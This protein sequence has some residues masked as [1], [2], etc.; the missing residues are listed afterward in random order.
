MAASQLLIHLIFLML[1]FSDLLMSNMETADPGSKNVGFCTHMEWISPKPAL[2][3]L[4]FLAAAFQGGVTMYHVALPVFQSK[5][6]GSQTIEELK[7]PSATTQLSQTICV[8]PFCL[9]RFP[10]PIYHQGKI[11]W[12]D[13]GPHAHPTVAILLNGQGNNVDYARLVVASCIVPMYGIKDTADMAK[14]SILD[15]VEWKGAKNESFPRGLIPCSCTLSSS[16]LYYADMGIYAMPFLS[17]LSLSSMALAKQQDQSQ[18]L[19]LPLPAVGHSFCSTPFGLNS[20]GGTWLG[21]EGNGTTDRHGVFHVFSVFQC[22]RKKAG[23]SN[24]SGTEQTLLEWTHPMRRHWLVRTVPG[25][26]KGAQDNDSAPTAGASSKEEKD[27]DDGGGGGGGD[28]VVTGGAASSVVCELGGIAPLA[29]YVPFSIVRSNGTYTAVLFRASDRLE[30]ECEKIAMIEPKEES[31]TKFRMVQLIDGQDIV[32]LPVSDDAVAQN[33]APRALI[34]GG[35]EGSKATSITMYQHKL[36]PQTKKYWHAGAAHRPILGVPPEDA[37]K[38]KGSEESDA[39]VE[40][41]KIVLS[42]FKNKVALL[43]VG[44][45][46]DDGRSCIISG[47]ME[48]YDSSD[49][50]SWSNL[51]PNIK[52]DPVFWFE[53]GEE[54]TL[55]ESLPWEQDIRGGVAVATN[56]RVLIL[57]PDEKMKLLGELRV[58]MSPSSLAPV[59]SFTVMFCSSDNRIRYVSGLAGRFGSGLIATLPMP[60]YGYNP[61][62]L[63]AVRP[64]RLLHFNWHCG[65]RLVE[66][67]QP[68]STFLLPTAITR[69]A[70]LLEP[71]LANAISTGGKDVGTQQFLRTIA[72]KFGRKVTSITH[73]DD[74]GIGNFGAGLTPKVFELLSRYEL[75][76]VASWFLTGT[77]RFDRLANSRLLPSWMPI[78]AKVHAALDADTHLHLIANGDQYFSEY[79]KS[80]D[81]NMTSTLPRPTDPSAFYCK[82]YA[83]SA[84]QDGNILDALKLLDIAGTESSESMLLQVSLALQADPFKDTTKIIESLFHSDSQ[85]GKSSSCTATAS[86]AALAQEIKAKKVQAGQPASEDFSKRW[87]KSLAPSLLRGKRTGRIRQRIIGE[88]AF[89]K[90]SSTNDR[91]KGSNLFSTELSEVRHVW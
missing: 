17:N 37:D 71:M 79:V 61:H 68:T 56:Q 9:A 11:A 25:D 24:D 74:E 28:E 64:D 7:K 20:S 69:P 23:T 18:P 90:I 72:E 43:A 4:L 85:M 54:V 29:N 53:P 51:L 89:A 19:S 13:L 77:V 57:S 36:N 21:S 44:T 59:G 47:R 50:V 33:G 52:E 60:R 42:R 32:F 22:E 40:C 35:N 16:V 73:G 46:A 70:L 30:L 87:M 66:M 10:G 62:L 15:T 26:C 63:L 45:R 76:E 14:L 75:K 6:K 78:S 8:K 80:P 91:T 82:E 38:Q 34:L 83:K 3:S 41:R 86:L 55:I 48:E 31:T 1:T 2:S 84:M 39:F 58:A 67:D 12:L 27:D 65:T 5:K 49:D 88:S 81:N